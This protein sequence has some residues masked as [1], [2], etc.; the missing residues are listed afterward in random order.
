MFVSFPNSYIEI[1]T[2]KDDG[3]RRWSFGEVFRSRW[4]TSPM[5]GIKA[6]IKK[7]PELCCPFIPLRT[8]RSL[9]AREHSPDHAVCWSQTSCLHNCE[10]SFCCLLATQS[11]V[12]IIAVWID[13]K[14]PRSQ[15]SGRKSCPL[16]SVPFL[17]AFSRS[18]DFP[19]Q[20]SSL[21]GSPHTLNI[22]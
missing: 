10:I 12:F 9:R 20:E 8:V 22:N 2:P 1:L 7:A 5:K 21:L 13:S 4:P 17:N 3:I 11:V 6:L 19:A 15:I 18:G 14:M 16:L